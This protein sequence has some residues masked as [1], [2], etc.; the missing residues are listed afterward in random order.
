MTSY[1]SDK[2]A[3]IVHSVPDVDTMKSYIDLAVA[4]G[5]GYV[6]V[7]DDTLPN[8]YDSLPSY[9]QVEVDYV[10]SIRQGTIAGR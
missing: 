7:T 6:Y 2:F 9:W 8:P 4:R 5:I 10:E 1:S 3:M